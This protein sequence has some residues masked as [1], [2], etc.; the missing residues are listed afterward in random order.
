MDRKDNKI[1]SNRYKDERKTEQEK[2]VRSKN[3]ED[4]Y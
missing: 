1:E 2:A 3:M 4:G